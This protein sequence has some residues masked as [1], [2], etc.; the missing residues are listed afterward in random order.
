MMK[1]IKLALTSLF[2][3]L[4]SVHSVWSITSVR[5]DEGMMHD[6]IDKPWSFFTVT[7]YVGIEKSFAKGTETR[8]KRDK[9]ASKK[10]MFFTPSVTTAEAT[11]I[12]NNGSATLGGEIT[13]I[14][15]S[16][17]TER[18]IVYALTTVNAAP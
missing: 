12:A 5:I 7:P 11:N 17:I 8:E 18:G 15:G 14:G 2:I 10:T 4:F 6:K 9:E 13:S 1:Y 3:L 16:A